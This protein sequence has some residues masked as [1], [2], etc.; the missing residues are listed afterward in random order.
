MSAGV[1]SVAVKCICF[2]AFWGAAVPWTLASLGESLVFGWN[3]RERGEECEAKREG[4]GSW[5]DRRAAGT[6][7]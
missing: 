1:L 4:R 3:R 6:S 5:G 2:A 7:R